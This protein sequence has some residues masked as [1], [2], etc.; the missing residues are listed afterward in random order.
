M[1]SKKIILT[2]IIA[3]ILLSS[4]CLISFDVQHKGCIYNATDDTVVFYYGGLDKPDIKVPI[5]PYKSGI[6]G[7][8][9]NKTAL[10]YLEENQYNE[11]CDTVLFCK[12]NDTVVW[13]PPFTELPLSYHNFFNKNSWE[14]NKHG[15]EGEY[16]SETFTITESDF[17]KK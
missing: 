5:A 7:Y 3:F 17:T 15:K 16:S 8:F 10:E 4:S 9:K 14:V 2:G 6:I 13:L 11:F 12:K 1:D